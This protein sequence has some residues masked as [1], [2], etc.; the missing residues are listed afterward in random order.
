MDLQASQGYI[1]KLWGREGRGGRGEKGR[2][3]E[4]NKRQVQ[5]TV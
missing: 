2:G 3:G 5:W 1:M 4:E